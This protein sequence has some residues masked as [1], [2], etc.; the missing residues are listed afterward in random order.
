MWLYNLDS[1]LAELAGK[2][3]SALCGFIKYLTPLTIPNNTYTFALSVDAVT[4]IPGVSYLGISR[5][6]GSV[7]TS[8]QITET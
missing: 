4:S 6:F 1:G 5:G 2:G 3:K 7:P 8:G